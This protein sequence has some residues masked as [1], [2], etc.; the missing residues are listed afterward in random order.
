M[1]HCCTFVLKGARF[2]KCDDR[3][4]STVQ[5]LK[6]AIPSQKGKAVGVKSSHMNLVASVNAEMMQVLYKA[7][8]CVPSKSDSHDS[9]GIL[10]LFQ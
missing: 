3:A 9:L 7:R 10:T 1:K 2:G 8:G 5:I 4:G 6:D